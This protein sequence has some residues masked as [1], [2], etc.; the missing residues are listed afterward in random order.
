[1]ILDENQETREKELVEIQD[2]IE[3]MEK[4][5]HRQERDLT[6]PLQKERERDRTWYQLDLG[7]QG[8]ES[9]EIDDIE[10][11][12]ERMGERNKNVNP[13]AKRPADTE[14]PDATEKKRNRK[15]FSIQINEDDV[16]S[17]DSSDVSDTS[18]TSS[19]NVEYI[20]DERALMRKLVNT[21][22]KC[23]VKA[24]KIKNCNQNKGN[25]NLEDIEHTFK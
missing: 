22:V 11:E 18:S 8:S 25:V 16:S 19:E 1:M 9:R 23:L 20:V 7:S 2:L 6:E 24:R 10:Q 15:D 13:E 3:I 14:N 5:E 4:N 17:S 21:S 12:Y